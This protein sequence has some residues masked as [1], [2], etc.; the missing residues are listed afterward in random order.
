MRAIPALL[1]LLVIGCRNGEEFECDPMESTEEATTAPVFTFTPDTAAPGE[2]F[3][4]A[5]V[6]DSDEIDYAAI[7]ELVFYGDVVD[8]TTSARSDELLATIA[9][10]ED[11]AEGEVDMVIVFEDGETIWVEGALNIVETP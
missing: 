1:A 7:S 3:I 6:A 4:T 10:P 11:A 5:L 2:I 8:C 9:I